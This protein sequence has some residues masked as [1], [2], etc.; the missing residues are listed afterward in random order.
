MSVPATVRSREPIRVEIHGAPAGLVV[1]LLDEAGTE[2]ARHEIPNGR[3]SVEFS[4]PTV[5]VPTHFV[6]TATY[7]SGKGSQI[8]V[9]D[10]TVLP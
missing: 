7:P 4:A 1:A 10:V 5:R 8:I 6:F 9:R 2:I 3:A